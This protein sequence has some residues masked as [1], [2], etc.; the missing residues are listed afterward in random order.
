MK[1]VGYAQIKQSIA[2]LV[3]RSRSEV[4]HHWQEVVSAEAPAGLLATAFAAGLLISTVPV[5]VFDMALA[6]YVM[7]RFSRLPRAPF[8]AAM[9]MTNNL[10][11]APVYATTPKVG[12]MVLHWLEGHTPVVAPEMVL[13]R[14]LVGYVIIAVGLALAGYALAGTGFYGYKRFVVGGSSPPL[15]FPLTHPQKSTI[16]F[17]SNNS[18]SK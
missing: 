12:G 8:V 13:L 11:M 6:A 4:R 18:M 1:R 17:I 14:V 16:I 9:A 3:N 10:V 2:H 15:R 7:R 5:P